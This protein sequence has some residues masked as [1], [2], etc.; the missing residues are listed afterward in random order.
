MYIESNKIIKHYRL[1]SLSVRNIYFIYYFIYNN[2]I[3]MVFRVK[4]II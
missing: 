2:N 3:V 1:Q 4:S